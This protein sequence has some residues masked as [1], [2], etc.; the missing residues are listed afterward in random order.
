M[1]GFE[2]V[3]HRKVKTVLERHLAML[4]QHYMDGC[5]ACRNG[6]AKDLQTHR[7][8]KESVA[9]HPDHLRQ[10]T[11]E[12]TPPLPAIQPAPPGEREGAQIPQIDNLLPGYVYSHAPLPSAQ[13]FN[14]DAYAQDSQHDTDFNPDMR[15]DE[16]TSTG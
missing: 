15:T 5:L 7:R 13:F 9:P 2:F 11:P 8:R 6:P 10:P 12:S 16:R 3:G 14:L 1:W 4:C